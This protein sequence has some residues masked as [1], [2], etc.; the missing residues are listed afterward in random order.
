MS[1][2]GMS[3][4]RSC[5]IITKV[6]MWITSPNFGCMLGG[7]SCIHRCRSEAPYY[8]GNG[9]KPYLI[10]IIYCQRAFTY[11]TTCLQ[12]PMV[13]GSHLRFNACGHSYFPIQIKD[14][15]VY[16]YCS[17]LPRVTCIFLQWS[18]L[19]YAIITR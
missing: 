11:R 19:S 5:L 3:G 12:L 13:A 4:H 2:Y 6:T 18:L 16:N 7:H 9:M 1:I 15:K 8:D 17:T 14:Y 10:L